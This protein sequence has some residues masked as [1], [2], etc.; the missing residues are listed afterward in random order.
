MKKKQRT[1]RQNVE[2]VVREGRAIPADNLHDAAKV[3]VYRFGFGGSVLETERHLIKKAAGSQIVK[4]KDEND[5]PAYMGRRAHNNR[6]GAP[7]GTRRAGFILGL[8]PKTSS[9]AVEA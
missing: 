9:K 8:R 2:K 4:Y 6:Q 3:I 1:P 7:R 5:N